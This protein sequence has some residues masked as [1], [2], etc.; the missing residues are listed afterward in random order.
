MFFL[1]SIVLISIIIIPKGR[2]PNKEEDPHAQSNL[3]RIHI[4]RISFRDVV[5]TAT[6]NEKGQTFRMNNDK[7][8]E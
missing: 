1:L 5:D 2:N 7:L 8:N 6:A 4:D 3:V